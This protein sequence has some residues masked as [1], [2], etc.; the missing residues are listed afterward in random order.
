[1]TNFSIR[2]QDY[3]TT[4]VVFRLYVI[5][6][7]IYVKSRLEIFAHP[8][9]ISLSEISKLQ[10]SSVK[11]SANVNVYDFRFK[12]QNFLLITGRYLVDG[13]QKKS[14]FPV[15][16]ICVVGPRPRKYL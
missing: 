1:M 13:H 6:C 2:V 5:Y 9:R 10:Q 11:F 15:Q 7:Y 3:P 14:I 8:K 16:A 12:F 4:D